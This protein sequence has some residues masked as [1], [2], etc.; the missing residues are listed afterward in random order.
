MTSNAVFGTYTATSIAAGSTRGARMARVLTPPA[1]VARND[2]AR[3]RSKSVFLPATRVVRRHTCAG[4][5]SCAEVFVV[6]SRANLVVDQG[7]DL[8][9]G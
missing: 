4:V 5:R 7:A 2:A 6:A 1:T 9:A 3:D 8:L